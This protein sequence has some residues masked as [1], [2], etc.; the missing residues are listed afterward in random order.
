MRSLSDGERAILAQ[1][2]PEEES[3]WRVLSERRLKA[4]KAHDCDICFKTC[5]VR[6]IRPGDVYHRIVVVEDG[7][8]KVLRICSPLSTKR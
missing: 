1:D 3:P 7:E 2:G 8:F 6:H 4:R 5:F